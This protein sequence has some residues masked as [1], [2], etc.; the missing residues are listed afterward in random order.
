LMSSPPNNSEGA[1][2]ALYDKQPG[3]AGPELPANIS[4]LT[5]FTYSVPGEILA[6]ILYMQSAP[7]PD[8]LDTVITL[9][10]PNP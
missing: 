5:K 8:I 9:S 10:Q 1:L 4:S 6:K 2:K 3:Y 7:N